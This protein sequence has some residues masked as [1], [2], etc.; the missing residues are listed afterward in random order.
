VEIFPEIGK[1]SVRERLFQLFNLLARTFHVKFHFLVNPGH[2]TE[3]L[4]K[5]KENKENLGMILNFQITWKNGVFKI[6]QRP[7]FSEKNKKHVISN[8]KNCG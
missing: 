5:T 4:R 1:S 6:I 3:F 8:P 2:L 7:S